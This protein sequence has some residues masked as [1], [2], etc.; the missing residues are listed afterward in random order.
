MSRNRPQ[1]LEAEVSQRLCQDSDAAQFSAHKGHLVES[2]SWSSNLFTYFEGLYSFKMIFKLRILNTFK[3][4][5]LSQNQSL[6]IFNNAGK[7]LEVGP[8]RFSWTKGLFL[9]GFCACC[10]GNYCFMDK[11]L[12]FHCKIKPRM[13]YNDDISLM[14]LFLDKTQRMGV[15]LLQK[16]TFLTKKKSHHIKISLKMIYSLFKD[17]NSE[18]PLLPVGC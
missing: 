16:H 3:K 7:E 5:R 6:H 2:G 8:Q 13:G 9:I 4:K 18:W 14:L 10:Y 1:C 11:A 17:Q 12:W 15:R